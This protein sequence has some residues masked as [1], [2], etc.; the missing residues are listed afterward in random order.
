MELE[1]LRS[2]L[3][4]ETSARKEHEV[5]SSRMWSMAFCHACSQLSTGNIYCCT[6]ASHQHMASHTKAVLV[7]LEHALMTLKSA[8]V[9]TVHAVL[10]ACSVHQLL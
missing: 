3:Q 5:G 4:L 1:V 7:L 9:L 2:Q 10:C 6:A 8:S